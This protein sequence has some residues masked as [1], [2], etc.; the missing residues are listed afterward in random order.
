MK[1]TEDC[2]EHMNT[3]RSDIDHLSFSERLVEQQVLS[4]YPTLLDTY[5]QYNYLLQY[6]L[7]IPNKLRV[8]MVF[9]VFSGHVVKKECRQFLLNCSHTIWW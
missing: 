8:H 4:I 3:E 7:L 9:S 6:N 1:E 5:I 2:H